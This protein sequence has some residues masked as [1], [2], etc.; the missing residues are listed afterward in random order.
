MKRN[1]AIRQAETLEEKEQK[2]FDS[3]LAGFVVTQIRPSAQEK[4]LSEFFARSIR[5]VKDDS[6]SIVEIFGRFF[7]HDRDRSV[8]CAR[9]I[10][11]TD[12]DLLDLVNNRVRDYAVL[13]RHRSIRVKP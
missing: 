8:R 9:V 1:W 3:G 6:R 2:I 4:G 11:K 10:F 7:R 12:R 13:R 5:L